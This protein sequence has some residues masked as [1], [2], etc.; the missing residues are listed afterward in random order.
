MREV[1]SAFGVSAEALRRMVAGR[2]VIVWGGNGASFEV[3]A[4]L[5]GRYG[6][7]EGDVLCMQPVGF[8]A[9]PG[10]SAHLPDAF[11][12]AN[13]FDRTR[14]FVIV[15]SVGFRRQIV[16][17]LEAAGAAAGQD[18]L[19]E[20]ELFRQRMVLRVLPGDS[21]NVDAIAGFL[22]REQAGLAGA[23]LEISGLP[24]PC[25]SSGLEHLLGRVGG[26]VPITL[27]SFVPRADLADL[28]NRYGLRLRLVA[29]GDDELFHRHFPGRVAPAWK[30]VLALIDRLESHRPLEL[31]RIG[32]A[33]GL[34]PE[35]P[36]LPNVIASTDISYPNDFSPL[37]AVA[38]TKAEIGALQGLCGFDLQAALAKAEA[39]LDRPCM[40]ERVYPVFR[41]DGGIAVCHL[42]LEGR[43]AEDAGKTSLADVAEG[44]AFH[45]YCRRCQAQ[46]IHRFDLGLLR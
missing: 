27:S 9:F 17:R 30:H 1:R 16:A 10:F 14:H 24:D 6:L 20:R 44:R 18:Y 15:A 39:Q 41:A 36:R 13:A 33:A 32:F 38:E 21:I 3:V 25:E 31:V 23:T 7:A 43:L 28:A 40:C 5:V 35:P 42:H 26:L 11:W 8:E 46:G 37:L 29:Y 19:H 45:D 22:E 4:A 2:R 12:A 34:P